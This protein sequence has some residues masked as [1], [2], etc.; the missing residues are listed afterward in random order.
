MADW[1]EEVFAKLETKL[2][3][4]CRRLAGRIPYRTTNGV[5]QDVRGK[6]HQLVENGFWPGILWQMY[7]A[8]GKGLYRQAAETAERQLDKAC[9]ILR[10]CT[11]TPALCG[12]T[13]PWPTTA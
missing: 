10:G 4:E 3:A 1:K 13:V 5:Y 9:T 11:M 6:G 7:H 8:T 12:C 2:E